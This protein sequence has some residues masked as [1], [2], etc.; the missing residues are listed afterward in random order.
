VPLQQAPEAWT[1]H[2]DLGA[3]SSIAIIDTGIDYTHADFGGIGTSDAYKYALAHDTVDPATDP[4][5]RQE[6]GPDAPKAIGGFDFVG[7]AYNAND[8]AHS[9]PQ[10]DKNPLDCNSHGTHTA[11]SLA[12]FGVTSDGKT[13]TGPYNE[14]TVTAHDPNHEWTVG[15]GAAPEASLLVYRVFGCAGSTNVDDLAINQAVKDG[16]SVISMSL[17]SPYGITTDPS[18]VAAQNAVNDGVT[19]VAADGNNGQNAYL[20]SSPASAN[21]AISVAAMD[22]TVPTYPGADLHLSTG[23]T[24]PTINANGAPLPSGTFPVDVLKNADGTMSLGCDKSEYAGS[25]SPPAVP[26][27]ASPVPCSVTRPARPPWSWSTAPTRCRRSRVRSPATRTP[28]SSTRSRSR[29][30]APS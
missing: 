7:D 30:W 28:A 10:P 15:P 5:L 16:A 21:G 20:T 2:G 4:Q 14:N 27:P 24:V 22:A 13:Y 1:A 19:V 3:R 8:P 11:G 6:F 17:G 23:K 18:A 26:V 25:S 12:G 29:S 9:T